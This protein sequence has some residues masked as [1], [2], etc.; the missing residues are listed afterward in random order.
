MQL[1]ERNTLTMAPEYRF[2]DLPYSRRGHGESSGRLPRLVDTTHLQS[3][4]YF[5]SSPR[6]LESTQPSWSV[7]EPTHTAIRSQFNGSRDLLSGFSPVPPPSSLPSQPFYRTTRDSVQHI[8]DQFFS[9]PSTGS[10]S[11]FSQPFPCPP[12]IAVR[13]QI[14]RPDYETA[15][16]DPRLLAQGHSFSDQ[17]RPLEPFY[18]RK[19]H[20]TGSYS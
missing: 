13:R 10:E 19:G 15:S 3:S 14:D 2:G 5:A 11:E 8:N 4:N 16:Q 7:P 20:D 9:L 18:N 6:S 12:N 17:R 1:T